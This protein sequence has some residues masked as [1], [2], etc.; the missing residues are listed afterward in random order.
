MVHLS[1][2]YTRSGDAGDTGLGD[3]TRVAKSDPRIWSYGE[4]DELGAVLGVCRIHCEDDEILA[5]IEM[6]QNDL[7]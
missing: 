1:K 6:I 7:F 4:V 5:E 3:G 2:I